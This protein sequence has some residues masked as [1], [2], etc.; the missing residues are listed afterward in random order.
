MDPLNSNDE[1]LDNL[2][3]NNENTFIYMKN[4]SK[5]RHCDLYSPD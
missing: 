5:A 4:H 2:K 3:R 1:N